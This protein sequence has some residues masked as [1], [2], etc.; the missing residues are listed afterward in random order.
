MFMSF[1]YGH[2]MKL[3][4]N[5]RIAIATQF[6]IAKTGQTHVSNNEIVADGYSYKDLE[7]NLKLAKLQDFLGS[8]ET[9]YSVLW[10]WLVELMEGKTPNIPVPVDSVIEVVEAPSTW[11][12]E[13]GPVIKDV[14]AVTKAKKKNVVKKTKN[15]QK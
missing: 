13:E 1:P 3:P 4:I 14:P 6:G 15:K 2:W 7:E 10:G 9:D 8:K 5:T 12:I 11:T